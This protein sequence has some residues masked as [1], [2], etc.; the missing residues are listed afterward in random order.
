MGS[1][2]T[3][4]TSYGLYTET[5]GYGTTKYCAVFTGAIGINTTTPNT[6]TY[7]IDVANQNCRQYS[8]TSWTTQE[9]NLT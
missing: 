2:G 6:T 4:T 7:G 8:S 9:S 1:G 5:P 3:C